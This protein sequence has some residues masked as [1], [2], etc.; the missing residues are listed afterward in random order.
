MDKTDVKISFWTGIVV[1]VATLVIRMVTRKE[2][3][4]IA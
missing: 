1:A 3:A 2:E 4:K